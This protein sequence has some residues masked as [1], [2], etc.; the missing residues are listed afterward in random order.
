MDAGIFFS[1][2]IKVKSEKMRYA[3]VGGMIKKCSSLA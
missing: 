1:E 2:E 3:A